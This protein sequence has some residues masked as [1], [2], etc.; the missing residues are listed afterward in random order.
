M[1]VLQILDGVPTENVCF[2]RKSLYG[3]REAPRIWHHLLARDLKGIGLQPMPSEPCVF[4]AD[5]VIVHCYVEDLLVLAKDDISLTSNK[6]N[7][8]NSFKRMT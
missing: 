1:S 7:S 4:R 3:L 5:G 8:R 6:K 2:I